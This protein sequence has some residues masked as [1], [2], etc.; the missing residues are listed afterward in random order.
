[1]Q[2]IYDK[3]DSLKMGRKSKPKPDRNPA[4]HTNIDR[5]KTPFTWVQTDKENVMRNSN[6]AERKLH[7]DQM[8]YVR[9][10]SLELHCLPL[11]TG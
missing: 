8:E 7:H 9:E 4:T 5:I 2:R 11:E 3:L 10:E 6:Q 1:M